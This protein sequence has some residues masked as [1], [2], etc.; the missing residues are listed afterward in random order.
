MLAEALPGDGLRK[1]KKSP[2]KGSSCTFWVSIF[3]SATHDHPKS[4]ALML[5]LQ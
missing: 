5:V 4:L 2:A 1:G 3:F